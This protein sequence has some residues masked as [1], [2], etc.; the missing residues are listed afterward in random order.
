M[1]VLRDCQQ[2]SWTRAEERLR[3][4]FAEAPENFDALPL[5]ADFFA[6]SVLPNCETTDA[7]ARLRKAEIVND[8]I[9]QRFFGT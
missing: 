6:I 2:R 5:L 3:E 4:G 1:A 7:V 9:E 8:A